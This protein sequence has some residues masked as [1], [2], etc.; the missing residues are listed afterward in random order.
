MIYN[1]I[2]ISY[3]LCLSTIIHNVRTYVFK[4]VSFKKKS[5]CGC[6]GEI[7]RSMKALFL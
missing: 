6:K 7:C 3:H 5:M 1:L 2:V 4:K